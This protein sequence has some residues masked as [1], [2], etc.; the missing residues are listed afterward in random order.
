MENKIL[1]ILGVFYN[2]CLQ[3]IVFLFMGTTA[4]LK[5]AA[6]KKTSQ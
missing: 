3:L 1:D 5:A 6:V 4:C 2:E